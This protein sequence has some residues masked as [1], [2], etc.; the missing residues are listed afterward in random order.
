MGIC[1]SM[2]M[3]FLITAESFVH[4]MCHS[5]RFC[6]KMMI[7]PFILMLCMYSTC[8]I[9]NCSTA[10]NNKYFESEVCQLFLT[11]LHTCGNLLC[12]YR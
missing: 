6:A 9:L 4:F 8:C 5:A 12:V 10:C 3:H 11:I 2:Q 1:S 7:S